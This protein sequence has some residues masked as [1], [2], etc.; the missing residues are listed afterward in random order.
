MEWFLDNST[1]PYHVIRHNVP[2]GNDDLHVSIDRHEFVQNEDPEADTAPTISQLSPQL[3]TV[4]P[5]KLSVGAPLPKCSMTIYSQSSKPLLRRPLEPNWHAG[6]SKDCGV[7]ACDQGEIHSVRA[8]Q[9]RQGRDA[10]GEQKCEDRAGGE[11]R[12][13]RRDTPA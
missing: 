11:E 13:D 9:Q 7:T 12:A 2:R 1:D 8:M 10:T 4:V 3:S 6:I 5:E